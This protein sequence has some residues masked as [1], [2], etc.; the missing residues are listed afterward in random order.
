MDYLPPYIMSRFRDFEGLE[1]DSSSS[2]GG[3]LP[4]PGTAS[5]SLDG[6]SSS[7]SPSCALVDSHAHSP[8]VSPTVVNTTQSSTGAVGEPPLSQRVGVLQQRTQIDPGKR[9]YLSVS[10]QWWSP[11]EAGLDRIDPGLLAGGKRIRGSSIRGYAPYT[12]CE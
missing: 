7:T 2:V 8:V 11:P 4:S 6:A 12:Q 9:I 3:S 1:L 10:R 5:C